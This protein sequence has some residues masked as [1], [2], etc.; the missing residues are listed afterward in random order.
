MSYGPN[1]AAVERARLAWA[2]LDVI[3]SE[4]RERGVNLRTS[5]VPLDFADV[6]RALGIRAPHVSTVLRFLRRRDLIQS[7]RGGQ[8]LL[9]PAV[10]TPHPL[11]A[12]FRPRILLERAR[13]INTRP[14]LALAVMRGLVAAL[15]LRDPLELPE[16]VQVPKREWERWAACDAGVAYRVLQGLERRALVARRD[17]PGTYQI[18]PM[19]LGHA[20]TLPPP[21][22]VIDDAPEHAVARTPMRDVGVTRA[23]PMA[24]ERSGPHVTV[25]PDGTVEIAAPISWSP[26]EL[27]TFVKTL[28]T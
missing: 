8:V 9:N 15:G 5:R 17:P 23:A 19:L 10:V 2:V 1:R 26:A 4:A 27:A 22:R 12:A 6:A 18:A 20:V 16:P 7:S 14:E 3:V 28:R 24:A 21:A 13:G 25:R 11:R